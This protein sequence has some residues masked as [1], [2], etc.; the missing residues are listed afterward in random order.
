MSSSTSLPP[1]NNATFTLQEI[2]L[3]TKGTLH[4]APNGT[5]STC[6]VITDTRLLENAPASTCGALFVALR[7]E[8]FDGHR[9]LESAFAQGASAA[10]V[11]TAPENQG[12]CISVDNTQNAL[13][14]LAK[15]HRA[16]FDIPLIGVTGSYGK[17]TTRAFIST[18]LAAKYDSRILA[19][20]GNYNNEIGVPLT[21]LALDKAQHDI[22][23]L[24]LAMR[25]SGQ[26]DYLAN[27]AQ[28][29]IGVITNIGPQHIE[30][31][32]SL[33]NIA[34]A[35][36]ELLAHLP[37]TGTAILPADDQFFELLKD[38]SPCE[39]IS[40]GT[41]ENADFRVTEFEATENGGR[42]VLVHND[43]RYDLQLPLPGLHNAINAA[44]AIAAAS[45]CGVE[46]EAA[47]DALAN[48]EV[49]GARMRL[50]RIEA[51]DLTIIDDCYNAGPDSMRAALQV[52]A[53]VPGEHRRVA[54]LGAMRELGAW[55]ESEHRKLGVL[56]MGSGVEVLVGVGEE[57]KWMLES[58]RDLETIHCNDAS[59]AAQ[60]VTNLVR[61]GDVILVKGSRSVG[62]EKVVTA[63]ASR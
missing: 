49:P 1:R 35:K 32:G 18:A 29:T 20:E 3:A 11:E 6:S 22:A 30:L 24:E 62:L 5:A 42:C 7:G 58:V 15:F 44:C 47:I 41:L 57:A 2:V 31:L 4:N 46:I 37:K 39:I 54:I 13:G 25:G 26:I 19:T 53:G 28:P 16:H 50:M 40:F 33:K 56:A 48:V 63:L 59:E 52:L 38:A 21:V 61:T 27:I 17:T 8:N 60:L 45:T 43:K 55:S 12:V 34:R 10:L 51:H 36:A 9:F 14:D 23:V